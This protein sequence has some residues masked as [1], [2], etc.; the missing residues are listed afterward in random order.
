MGELDINQI[1][2]LIPQRYPFLLIDKVIQIEAWEKV[3]AVKN[4]TMNEAFFQG[5]FPGMPIM[6]GVLIVEAMAQAVSILYK[7]GNKVSRAENYELLLASVKSRFLNPAYPGDQML[8]EATPVK[9]ISTGGIASAV[10][11]VGDTVVCNTEIGFS[12]Q[13]I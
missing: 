9:F 12:V 5:H 7:F 8:I 2:K 11:R 1:M 13:Y 6:P 4:L 10:S 3:V